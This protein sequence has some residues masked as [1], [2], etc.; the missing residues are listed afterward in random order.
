[1]A[2][3]DGAK[4][5]R[6]SDGVLLFVSFTRQTNFFDMRLKGRGERKTK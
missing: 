5:R 6:R 3:I 2:R 4:I 1:M